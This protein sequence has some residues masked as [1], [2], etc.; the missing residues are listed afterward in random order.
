MEQE[1][2][3]VGP[4]HSRHG[5]HGVLFREGLALGTGIARAGTV[6]LGQVTEPDLKGSGL[7]WSCE[8]VSDLEL[9]M[10]GL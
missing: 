3:V 4:D 7:L 6:A 10:A 2:A 9:G 8:S 1:R 5:R